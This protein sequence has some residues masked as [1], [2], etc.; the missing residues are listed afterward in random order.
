MRRQSGGPKSQAREAKLQSEM[1]NSIRSRPVQLSMRIRMIVVPL[2]AF[3]VLAGWSFSSPVGSSPD[4]DFHLASI[5]C[6]AGDRTSLCR[7]T[8][9]PGSRLLAEPFSQ[10]PCFARLSSE[11]GAC[12]IGAF[13]N[14][15]LVVSDRGNFRGAY[16]PVFYATMAVLAS[17]DVQASTLAMRLLNAALFVGLMTALFVL[18]PLQHR[19]MAIGAFLI[20]IVPLGLFLIPSINPSSWAVTGVGVA[21]LA[22]LG[23]VDSSGRRQWSLAG[24]FVVGMLMAAGSRADAGIYAVLAVL[25]V[26][27]LRFTPTRAF[28]IVSIVP[29]LAA[30]VAL[31]ATLNAGQLAS[32]AQGFTGMALP[33]KT[34]GEPSAPLEAT[35]WLKL[36]ATNIVEA[37]FLWA[38]VFGFWSLGWFDTPMPAVVAF[39][40]VGVFIAV[41]FSGLAQVDWRKALVFAG[42]AAA[43]WFIPTWTLTRGGDQ[44]GSEVQ[45]RYLLPLIVLLAGFALLTS[46]RRGIRLSRAQRWIVGLTLIGAQSLSLYVNFRRYLTGDDVEA[47]NLNAGVEWW[48]SGVISPMA[49]WF[50]ASVA[51]AIVI[52]LLLSSFA[53]LDKHGRI[54]AADLPITR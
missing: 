54:E 5:W 34:P 20:S 52:A 15:K 9:E 19:S 2:L 44:V 3:C 45:P 25:A 47:V 39:G 4:E 50:I 13:D 32:A 18:L 6:S 31:V 23:Y 1:Q 49:F 17:D 51:W 43:L 14:P 26:L 8:S 21:W 27:F 38:G 42:A 24:I 46:R 11:S 41:A 12:Q 16:P 7:E 48:W 40:S 53:R 22:L 37:P 29:V 28:L 36:A 33:P 35:S 30:T 10:D